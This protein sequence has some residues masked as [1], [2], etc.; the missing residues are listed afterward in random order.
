[1]NQKKKVV[2]FFS[3]SWEMKS[4][5]AELHR[6]KRGERT[7]VSVQHEA[8]YLS[9]MKKKKSLKQIKNKS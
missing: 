9:T 4:V 7:R 8:K 6:E 3:Y 1:L 2:Q 5:V